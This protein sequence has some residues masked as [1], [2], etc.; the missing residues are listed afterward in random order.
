MSCGHVDNRRLVADGKCLKCGGRS[1]L[2][3]CTICYQPI[4]GLYKVCLG[5]GHAAHVSC[6]AILLESLAE[7]EAPECEA[8]CGCVCEEKISV[9][10][11]ASF[12]MP[13]PQPQP[14]EEEVMETGFRMLQPVE[15][16]TILHRRGSIV[17]ARQAARLRERMQN[18]AVQLNSDGL[19]RTRTRSFGH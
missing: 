8:G 5:C 14:Q 9:G 4:A 1:H 7:D 15:N 12:G 18:E 16:S 3:S 19:R 13:A 17:E 11:H 2:L 6:L 10:D